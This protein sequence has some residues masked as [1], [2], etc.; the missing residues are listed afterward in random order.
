MG[1]EIALPGYLMT[2]HPKMGSRVLSSL[3]ASRPIYILFVTDKELI[4][5]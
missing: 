3:E 2:T 4:Y 5:V 1:K